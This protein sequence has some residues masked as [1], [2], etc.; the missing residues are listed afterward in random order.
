MKDD[1]NFFKGFIFLGVLA[2]VGNFAFWGGLIWLAIWLV[3]K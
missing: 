1:D 2:L 3:Q